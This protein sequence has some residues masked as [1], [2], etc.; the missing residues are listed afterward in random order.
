MRGP[1]TYSPYSAVLRDRVV[2]VG[3]AALVDQV[4]D[5]LHLVQA[6]EIGH[7]RRVAG[8]DQRLVAGLDQLDQAAA[9]HGLLAEQVGLAFFLEGGLDD[10]GA[11]AADRRGV[12]QAEVVRVA[13]RRPCGSRPG[14][15]RRRRADTRERTVWPGPFGAIMNT[16]RSARGSIRLKW[17]LRP[18]ANISAAP[19]F[20]L[21]CEMVAVDVALQLVGREHHHHVGPF[22]GLG[23]LHHL[24]ASPSAFLTPLASPCAA[25]PRR[26]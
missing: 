18:W 2:H 6:L 17:T 4:D 20:M 14:R 10:A 22:G 5:Q 12:G 19:F 9:Q 24:E 3:D 8:L 15:A 1:V 25:P 23:D 11:A 21:A 26:P 7:L 16:S 13:R